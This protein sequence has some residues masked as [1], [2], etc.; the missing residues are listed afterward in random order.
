MDGFVE[1]GFDAKVSNIFSFAMRLII[2][3]FF[4][5]HVVD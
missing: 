3:L 1:S 5:V 4:G 2:S